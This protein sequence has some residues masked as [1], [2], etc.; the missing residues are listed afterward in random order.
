MPNILVVDDLEDNI[1]L[2]KHAL[3]I[4][5]PECTV[6]EALGGQEGLDKSASLGHDLDLV[7][8]DA[9][10]PGVNGFQVCEYIKGRPEEYHA[11][12]LMLSAVF[13]DSKDRVRGMNSGADSYLCKP[14]HVEELMA[15]VRVLL[16]IKEN[17]DLLRKH[18]ATLQEKLIERTGDLR[19]TEERLQNFFDSSPD[20]IYVA[21]S[22]GQLLEANITACQLHKIP[23]VDLLEKRFHDLIP[24]VSRMAFGKE[25]TQLFDGDIEQCES[26]FQDPSGGEIPIEM[27]AKSIEANG[28]PALLLHVRN[29]ADRKLM[30]DQIRSAQKM[31]AVGRLA[32][33]I[34]H[35][36]NNL[37][38]SILG[39]SHLVKESVEDEDLL[40]DIEQ[41]IHSADRCT[42]LTR[43]L[44]IFGRK[45]MLPMHPVN[46]NSVVRDIDQLLR[47]TL[48]E[49]IEQVTLMD[50]SIGAINADEGQLEQIILNLAINARDAMPDGGKLVIETRKEMLKGGDAIARVQSIEGE[51]VSL[52]ISDQGC[53][54]S[55]EMVDRIY[56]PFFTTKDK[57]N[58]RGLGLSTVYGIVK[59]CK[60]FIEVDT[61]P[62][63]GTRFTL[64]FP[65]VELAANI[66]KK[67]AATLPRG[68]ETILLV[69]DEELVL[70]LTRRILTSL[71]Y[72]VL[73]ARNGTEA[74]RIAEKD[75]AAIDLIVS[76]V[77]MP[78]MGGPE[79]VRNIREM[80]PDLKVLFISGFTDDAISVSDLEQELTDLLPKPFGKNELAQRVRKIIDQP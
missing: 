41:I 58:G 75:P 4:Y 77:I 71:G 7:I 56:E 30:E 18:Q 80:R 52:H 49:H 8:L 31:D 45:Q 3:N 74:I 25:Y 39:Y 73:E 35:D 60:G 66:P 29:I 59:H 13:V 43:Q 72:T 78:H 40:K 20:A 34:A 32:G 44:L 19:Q 36:F 76:D 61:R 2:V 79:M 48:G 64:Y 23:L 69:E 46:L 57:E 37:L 70:Q 26:A 10:M 65:V 12:I 15:Q 24:A 17:E 53:G 42:N 6:H 16:R 51:Y 67:E 50:E 38:T 28:V 5:M 27:L 11:S 14:Y 47:R 54:I 63:E 55:R 33:G 68:T 21:D 9:N 22:K 62:G 1:S